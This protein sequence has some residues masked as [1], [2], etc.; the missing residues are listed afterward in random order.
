MTLTYELDPD[1][2]K[3]YVAFQKY[4]FYVE[5]FKSYKATRTDRNTERHTHTRTHTVGAE[6]EGLETAGAQNAE[7]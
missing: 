5:A 1:I 6:N 4:S 7:S 2:L 3:A